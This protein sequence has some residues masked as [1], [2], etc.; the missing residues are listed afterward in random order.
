MKLLLILFNVLFFFNGYTQNF[1][2]RASVQTIELFFGFSNWDIQLEQAESND[3]YILADSIRINGNVLDSVGVKYKGNS[4]YNPNNNKN[5][6]HIELD[7]FKGSHDF[8]GYTDI[9][10]QNGFSDPSMIREVLSYAIL[11]QYMDCPKSNFANVYINGSLIGLYSNAESINKKFCGENYYRNDEARVKCN[12]VGGAGP[13]SSAGPDLKFINT[14]TTSY[15][16][17]YEM[18]SDHG[19][20]QLLDLINVLNNNFSQIEELL[21]VDRAL[22]MLAY[23]NVLVNLDSY[24]GAFRQNYYLTWDYNNR[25][26]STVWDLNMSFGGFPGGT[27]SGPGSGGATLDPLSNNTSSNHP[28]IVKMLSNERYKKMYLAHLRT[29]VQEVFESQEYLSIANQLRTTIDSYVQADPNKFYTYTQFQNSLTTN[30]TGGGPP[31][32]SIPGLQLLMN[33]RLNYLSTNS[34]YLLSPPLFVSQT[35]SNSSPNFGDE[36]AFNFECSNENVV[37][38]GY[39]NDTRLKFNKAQMFDDG[40]HNDGAAGDHVYGISLPIDGVAFEYYFYTENTDAGLFYPARAEHE[41]LTLEIQASPFSSGQVVINEILASNQNFNYDSNGED[42]D[43]IELYNLEN[44]AIDLS[45]LFLSD[46]IGNLQKYTFPSGTTIGP[47]AMLLVWCD[48]DTLQQGIHTNFK[49]SSTAEQVIFSDGLNIYDQVAWNNLSSNVAW[50]RCP[51]GSLSFALTNPTP[52]ESNNCFA[53]LENS[54][55]ENLVIYPNPS[56]GEFNIMLSTLKEVNLQIIDFKGCLINQHKINSNTQI[57]L[58]HLENGIYY[59]KFF[60]INSGKYTV[61]KVVLLH[62]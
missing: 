45:G 21:D 38:I 49:L 8:Q 5:P 23:N 22:W 14:D 3:T 47:N 36:V 30:I 24:N 44:I 2:D 35:V 20:S 32:S 43:W 53:S 12:P 13:G 33:D 4:S 59:F 18:K 27:G 60:E 10:L 50:A 54:S 46:D 19:W 48:N 62:Q 17:S 52:E 51:D 9:K 58:N 26:A 61:R 39:R 31:G 55:I 34:N 7:H 41:F 40:N 56:N 29:I 57:N 37:F 16:S 28:L 1:Y 25:F 15:Y 42:D 6:L 11:E